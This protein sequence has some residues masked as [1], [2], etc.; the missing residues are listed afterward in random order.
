M[1]PFNIVFYRV[2]QQKHQKLI[3]LCQL[4]S[5]INSLVPLHL[6]TPQIYSPDESLSPSEI[7]L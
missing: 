1:L 5:Q 4:Q 6:S 3:F 2:A 7:R